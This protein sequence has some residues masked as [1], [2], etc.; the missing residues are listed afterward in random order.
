M[1]PAHR[2]AAGAGFVRIASDQFQLRGGNL[3][4]PF[5]NL[6]QPEPERQPDQPRDAGEDE[7]PSPAEGV[8]DDGNGGGSDDGADVRTGVE[9]GRGEGALAF[10]EPERHGLDGGGEVA[11]LADAERHAGGEE[12]AYRA[13]Q[14]VRHGGQTPGE[15]RD[16]VADLRAVAVDEPAEGE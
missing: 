5:G 14:R 7:G 2:H 4:P 15:D 8:G 1:N 10:R 9:D 11:T 13:D 6:V 16:R 12:S 3:L